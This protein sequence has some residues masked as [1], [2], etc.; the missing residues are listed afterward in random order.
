MLWLSK[1]KT[2]GITLGTIFKEKGGGGLNFIQSWDLT[3]VLL[4]FLDK[5]IAPIIMMIFFLVVFLTN[6]F[7]KIFCKDILKLN[8]NGK[9]SY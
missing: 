1:T 5:V 2:I 3:R 8:N 6:L 7:L 9:K 4:I